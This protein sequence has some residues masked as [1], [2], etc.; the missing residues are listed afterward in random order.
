MLVLGCDVDVQTLTCFAAAVDRR[1]F[2]ICV[3]SLDI[4]GIGSIW[5]QVVQEGIVYISWN[6]DLCGEEE[7]K[8]SDPG[9]DDD[10]TAHPKHRPDHGHSSVRQQPGLLQTG[11]GHW[12]DLS[13]AGGYIM[14]NSFQSFSFIQYKSLMGLD[15][16]LLAHQPRKHVP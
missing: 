10:L 13:P 4:D 2:S 6:Q 3:Q 15:P 16:K 5:D 12:E 9:S 14:G 11:C 7:F 1:S 8:K